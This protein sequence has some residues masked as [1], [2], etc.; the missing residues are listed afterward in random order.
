MDTI[1][2]NAITMVKHLTQICPHFP[3]K[4]IKMYP[5]G[6]LVHECDIVFFPCKLPLSDHHR[7]TDPK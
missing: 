6:S 7:V 2:N 5:E 3:F 1:N 4:W